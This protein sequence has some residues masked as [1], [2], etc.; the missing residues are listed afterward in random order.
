MIIR[1]TKSGLELREEREWSDRF[2]E[3]KYFTQ[4]KTLHQRYSPRLR[5]MLLNPQN[6]HKYHYYY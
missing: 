4:V 3:N 2:K 6:A 5:N 1:K